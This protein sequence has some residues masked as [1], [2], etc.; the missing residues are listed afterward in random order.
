M[1]QEID[2]TYNQFIKLESRQKMAVHTYR[3][4]LYNGTKGYRFLQAM[5][6]P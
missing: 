3:L 5:R 6:T 2:G 1:T 4:C